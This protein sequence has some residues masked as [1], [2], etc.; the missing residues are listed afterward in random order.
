MGTFFV[1]ILKSSICLTIF[2]LFYRLLLS[3]ETFHRF[4]RIALLGILGLSLLIPLCEVTTEQPKVMIDWQQ[5]IMMADNSNMQAV[6]VETPSVSW[7]EIILLCYL[8]GLFFFFFRNLYSLAIVT[9][10]LKSGQRKTL[11]NGIILIV[12][13]NHKMAPFSWMRYVVIS[14][15]DLQESGR[16]ILIHEIAHIKHRHSMDLLVAEFCTFFHWFNPAAWLMKQEIQNIHEYEAD[17]TVINQG[18]DAKQYQLLLIK[19]AVGTRLYSMANSF[20]HSKLKKRITMMLKEKSNPWARVKYL[21]VLPLAALAVAAF[22]RPE[23]SGKLNEISAVEVNDLSAVVK[24]YSGNNISDEEAPDNQKQAQLVLNGKLVPTDTASRK[25]Q[26]TCDTTTGSYKTKNAWNAVDKLSSTK[27]SEADP[28]ILV[29][30]KEITKER[31]DVLDPE[32]IESISVLKDK[33]AASV[34]GEKGKNGVVL[35]R[36]KDS[37]KGGVVNLSSQPLVVMDGIELSYDTF[38]TIN[39]ENIESIS[40]LKDKAATSIY[41]E[42]GKNGVIIIVTKK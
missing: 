2:Y 33:S 21:Y 11:E 6:N 3:R 29:D 24:G 30:E 42:K 15:V 22:A 25:N 5:L 26:I 19:K 31:L 39:P 12:H 1:Y 16:E 32:K 40:V 37:S 27:S 8:V 36:T 41:G 35:I 7:I 38:Q 4:N 13:Q 14:S 9:R 18:I 34:Y 20:N 23:I 17:E 10:L 28:L